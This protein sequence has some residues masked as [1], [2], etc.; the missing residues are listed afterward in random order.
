MGVLTCSPVATAL[1]QKAIMTEIDTME[2]DVFMSTWL[3]VDQE[4]IVPLED[5]GPEYYWIFRDMEFVQW[6]SAARSRILWLSGP[7]QFPMARVSAHLVDVWKLKPYTSVLYFYCTSVPRPHPTATYCVRAL[8]LQILMSLS[9]QQQKL[10]ILEFSR[11]LLFGILGRESRVQV[12]SG[13]NQGDSTEEIVQKLLA[14]G[15]DCYSPADADLR[16]EIEDD[17]WKALE[18]T[19]GV[20]STGKGQQMAV[21]VDGLSRSD[22]QQ[23]AE[24]SRAIFRFIARLQE[25]I[26]VVKA[27]LTG[28]LQEELPGNDVNCIQYDKE[29]LGSTAPS[30]T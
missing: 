2:P 26:P 12:P 22:P 4:S 7:P 16:R 29:R 9:K 3:A 18:S 13:F 20:T 14:A 15:S 27:L 19:L 5:R 21:I 24:F 28:G 17:Y 25:R 1:T 10:A 6:E 8:L 23:S 11:V 30:S